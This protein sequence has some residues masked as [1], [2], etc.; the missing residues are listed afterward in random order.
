MVEGTSLL[1]SGSPLKPFWRALLGPAL[2]NGATRA[3][4]FSSG[5]VMTLF[6]KMGVK[7]L[8]GRLV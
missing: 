3:V 4:P 5:L 7:Q 1:C 2:V 8:G 6:G